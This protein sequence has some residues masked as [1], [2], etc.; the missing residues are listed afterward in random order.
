MNGRPVGRKG[1]LEVVPG[2]GIAAAVLAITVG[3]TALVGTSTP[4]MRDISWIPLVSAGFG[5]VAGVVSAVCLVRIHPVGRLPAARTLEDVSV[6]SRMLVFATG[7]AVVFMSHNLY[8]HRAALIFLGDWV[9]AVCAL[10]A[11]VAGVVTATCVAM[12]A[13]WL[14]AQVDLVAYESLSVRRTTT[15]AT[16]IVVVVGALVTAPVV[17]EPSGHKLTVVTT[18]DLASPATDPVDSLGEVVYRHRLRTGD[19]EMSIERAGDG[20]LVITAEHIT[21]YGGVDGSQRWRLDRS[22]EHRP[23]ESDVGKTAVEFRSE[24]LSTVVATVGDFTVGI[25]GYTGKILWRSNRP[26]FAVHQ[27]GDWVGW[28]RVKTIKDEHGNRESTELVA[29]DLRAGKTRWKAAMSCS[30]PAFATGGG[31]VVSEHCGGERGKV[32]LKVAEWVS[33]KTHA[34]EIAPPPMRSLKDLQGFGDGLFAAYFG[35]HDSRDFEEVVVFNAVTGHEIDRFEAKPTTWSGHVPPGVLVAAEGEFEESLL[36]IRDLAAHKSRRLDMGNIF[37]LKV[38][39]SEQNPSVVL[40][41]YES[42]NE[43]NPLTGQVVAR[44]PDVCVGREYRGTVVRV[45]VAPAATVVQCAVTGLP[46]NTEI[47]GFR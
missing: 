7:A 19:R 40:A 30:E 39:G 44:N 3:A 32:T 8:D 11:G 46:F 15:T 6:V 16:T 33:G 37:G 34:I 20:F 22:G 23:A 26:E 1:G 27:Y 18:G 31:L 10:A 36:L 25:D 9:W 24:S 38:R 45:V 17:L 4:Q 42:V 35:K 13:A 47:I 14:G 12:A 28:A 5:L 2:V 41:T 43:V 29:L 21:A